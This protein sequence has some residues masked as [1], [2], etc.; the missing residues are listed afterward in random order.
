[1]YRIALNVAIS[2][3][4]KESKAK[5][6]LPFSESL[7]LFEEDKD[8]NI[9]TEHHLRVLLA[10][11]NELKEVDKSVMLLYLDDKSYKEISAITGI[12]E[13]NVSTKINRIKLKL[14]SHF[15]KIQNKDDG[16]R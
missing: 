1:M 3:Y 14:K 10:F 11:I 7:I 12:S 16:T 9:E 6:H 8:A 5:P 13:S 4:R 2:F 15:I